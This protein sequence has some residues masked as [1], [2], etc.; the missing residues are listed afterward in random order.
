M[1]TTISESFIA[2]RWTVRALIGKVQHRVLQLVQF[3]NFLNFQ[4]HPRNFYNNLWKFHR[5][6][7]NGVCPCRESAIPGTPAS[8]TFN[9]LNFQNHPGDVYNNLWKF[10][11]NRMNGVCSY[12]GQTHRHSFLYIRKKIGESHTLFLTLNGYRFTEL[13]ILLLD[14]MHLRT[15]V[16]PLSIHSLSRISIHIIFMDKSIHIIIFSLRVAMGES[17]FFW[18]KITFHFIAET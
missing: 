18:T 14:G 13:L 15:M 12:M 6:R 3:S 4:N 11:R 10:N 2:I 5:N 7:M 8:T 9:F 16:A 1:F 17:S